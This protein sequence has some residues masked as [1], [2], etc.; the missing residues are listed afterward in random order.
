MYTFWSAKLKDVS[1]LA[2][3][4]LSDNI[5]QIVIVEVKEAGLE[6]NFFLKDCGRVWSLDYIG[7]NEG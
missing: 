2:I 5:G 7:V 6:A 3:P 4:P 1:S